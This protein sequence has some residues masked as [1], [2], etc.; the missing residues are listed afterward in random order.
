MVDGTQFWTPWG[1]YGAFGG[2]AQ[3]LGS[4]RSGLRS[5]EGHTAARPG[6]LVRVAG[7]VQSRSARAAALQ[8]QPPLRHLPRYPIPVPVHDAVAAGDWASTS[9]W[10]R[11][12]E[13]T[14]VL[15]HPPLLTTPGDLHVQHPHLVGSDLRGDHYDP[16]TSEF[17]ARSRLSTTA[18]S[19]LSAIFSLAP[20]RCG[21]SR[22]QSVPTAILRCM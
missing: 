2:S 3:R 9:K 15:G 17:L 7:R 22:H 4:P 18:S 14:I 5:R 13:A 19:L 8:A 20:V 12:R 11:D 10:L 21:V 6:Q 16:G 1:R